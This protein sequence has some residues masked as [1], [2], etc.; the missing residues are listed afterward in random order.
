MPLMNGINIC[1]SSSDKIFRNVL[2]IFIRP[3][4]RKFFNISDP[5]RMKMLIR[6]RLAFSLLCKHEFRHGF[7]DL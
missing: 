1:N 2:S 3:V 5:F 7:Q 4:E 6:L